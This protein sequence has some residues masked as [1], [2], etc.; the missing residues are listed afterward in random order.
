MLVEILAV[1]GFELG[2]EGWGC[3][4][5][6]K[7]VGSGGGFWVSPSFCEGRFASFAAPHRAV[8]ERPL[9]VAVPL[10]FV[11][12]FWGVC[13][14]RIGWWLFG[15]SRLGGHPLRTLLSYVLGL[16]ASPCASRRG[17]PPLSFGHFPRE[18]GK[19]GHSSVPGIPRG[20]ASL[21]RAPLR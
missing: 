11:G 13:G 2:C 12:G 16:C 3:W 6:K 19:P 4:L 9:R 8:L 7:V 14:F 17:G 21:V 5:E 10:L 1:G 18:R 15:V 20:L